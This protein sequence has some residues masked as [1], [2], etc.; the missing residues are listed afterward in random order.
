MFHLLFCN[1]KH[2][3]MFTLCPT[4]LSVFPDFSWTFPLT[5][6]VFGSF[7]FRP[8]VLWESL[9]CQW[10]VPWR[11]ARQGEQCWMCTGAFLSSTG[12]TL[13]D[14]W[15]VDRGVQLGVSR[16]VSSQ[17]GCGLFVWWL[18]LE[19]LR[20][21]QQNLEQML[22]VDCSHTSPWWDLSAT[23]LLSS[24]VQGLIK[25][26][27]CMYLSSFLLPDFLVKLLPFSGVRRDGFLPRIKLC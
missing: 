19:C 27:G 11:G 12:I 10:L 21:A 20:T 8:P 7:R 16:A 17:R 4:L 25:Q 2:V 14:D 26:V 15:R 6:E 18:M 13:T 1:S 23:G 5:S 3:N 22:N 9:W 24:F